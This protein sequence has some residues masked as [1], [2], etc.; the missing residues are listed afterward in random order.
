M[1]VL[2]GQA[3]GGDEVV[4]GADLEGAV[5]VVGILADADLVVEELPGQNLRL[6]CPRQVEVARLE[7]CLEA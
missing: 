1:P 7:Q 2:R 4:V 6:R 3:E 5:A